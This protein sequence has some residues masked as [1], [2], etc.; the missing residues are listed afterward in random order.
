[1]NGPGFYGSRDRGHFGTATH[2]IQPTGYGNSSVGYADIPDQYTH[3]CDGTE[4]SHWAQ[5][6]GSVALNQK[7]DRILGLIEAQRNESSELKTELGE[8]KAKF[9]EVQEMAVIQKATQESQKL[10]KELSVSN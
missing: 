8:L 2:C 1:M 10:P 9:Q 4:H 7:L 3:S 6:S 5:N